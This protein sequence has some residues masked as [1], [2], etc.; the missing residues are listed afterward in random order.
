MKVLIL[1]TRGKNPSLHDCLTGT[2]ADISIIREEDSLTIPKDPAGVDVI[3][4][5]EECT[6]GSELNDM[7]LGWRAHPHT[8][9]IPVWFPVDRKTFEKTSL[10]PGLAIDRFDR[11][12]DS[13]SFEDWLTAVTEWQQS[14]MHFSGSG[15]LDARSALELATS[16]C[17]RRASGVLSVFDDEGGK[18]RMEF[19]EGSLTSAS[20]RHLRDREAF[21]EFLCMSRG[22]FTWESSSASPTEGALQPL[23]QLICDGLE[24]IREGNLLYRFSP[25]FDARIRKTESQSA[26]DDSATASFPEQNTIYGLIEGNLSINQILEASPLSRPSTMTVLARW[27]SLTDITTISQ[28]PAEAEPVEPP[29]NVLVVDDSALMCKA[30]QGIF[31]AD[32]RLRI[33]GIAHDG[34]EALRLI[35]ECKPDVVTLDLQMPKMDGLT[36]LK[37]ILIRD[38]RPVV[39]LSAFTRET[40]SQTYESFKYGAVDVL[41]KPAGGSGAAFESEHR[42]LC[43]R[44]FQA[45]RVQ[46]GAIQY[47]RRRKRS[48]E[49][50][51]QHESASPDGNVTIVLCGAGGFPSL[52]RL[53]FSISD[54]GRMPLTLVGLAMSRRAV[55]ALVVNLKKDT[56]VPVNEVSAAGPL[57]RNGCYFLSMERGYRLAGDENRLLIEQ[58]GTH[59]HGRQAFDTLLESAAEALGPR[60][61]AVLISGTGE[62]G[63][64]GMRRVRSAGGLGLALS[65]EVCIRPD[66]SR[67]VIALGYAGEVKTIDELA[68]WFDAETLRSK[69]ELQENHASGLDSI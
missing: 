65:P 10:W 67:K 38:P 53:I 62:D 34:M 16:L 59:P 30:L 47:I 15:T 36:T 1:D 9:L 52:L 20:L 39:V 51:S 17:L 37:H 26:L 56:P 7:V 24:Q 35:G 43:D 2:R 8:Y 32:P 3:I 66:L 50:E 40:S 64:E 54:P 4:A 12:Y 19:R 13:R 29:C 25:D 61:A 27:F 11:D 58:N 31:S 33:A 42:E 41:A 68:G 45:S 22:A 14:R 49:L 28:G 6:P 44:V 18:G 63:I 48:A 23:S 21:F 60:L 46:L 57:D 55:E 69:R 5:G